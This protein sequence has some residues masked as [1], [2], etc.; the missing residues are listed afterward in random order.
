MINSFRKKLMLDPIRPLS[1]GNSYLIDNKVP[2]SHTWSP[3]FVPRCIDWP[4]HVDVVGELTQIQVG[5]GKVCCLSINT[6]IYI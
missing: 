3:T 4:S 1:G 6:Y 5:N 2:I